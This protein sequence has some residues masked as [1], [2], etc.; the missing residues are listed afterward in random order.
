MTLSPSGAEV[1]AY[2][3]EA[4][5]KFGEPTANMLH[6][7]KDLVTHTAWVLRRRLHDV[8]VDIKSVSSVQFK[9]KTYRVKHV[10]DDPAY[11]DVGFACV[12]I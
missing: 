7:A 11:P 2:L 6:I 3:Q 9:N 8:S 10:T 5:D 12:V 1:L 4:S